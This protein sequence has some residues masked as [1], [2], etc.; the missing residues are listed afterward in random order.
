MAKLSVADKLGAN[1]F[2]VF[3]DKSHINVDKKYPDAEE[4]NRVI[5]I[6]PAALYT[7]DANGFRF[8]YIGCLECGACRVLSG[9]KVVK[10]WNYPVGSFGVS[11]RRS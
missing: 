10:E 2:N 5:R 1:K 7:A 11:F 9:G 8:D 4:V 6:C 3:E